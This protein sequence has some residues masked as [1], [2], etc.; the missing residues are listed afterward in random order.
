MK[1]YICWRGH[2]VPKRRIDCLLGSTSV[3]RR[4]RLLIS[5]L[6]R[7]RLLRRTNST[8]DRWIYCPSDLCSSLSALFGERIIIFKASTSRYRGYCSSYRWILLY[9]NISIDT[10]SSS[11]NRIAYLISHLYCSCV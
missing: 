1:I 5:R 7:S 9:V 8:I 10:W 2:G 3:R 6:K 4:R 11:F